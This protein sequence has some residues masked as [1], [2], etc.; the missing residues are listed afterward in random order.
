MKSELHK[1][2]FCGAILAVVALMS[3]CASGET[4]TYLDVDFESGYSEG[5]LD[6]QYGG[7]MSDVWKVKEPEE[8]DV[9]TAVALDNK[10]VASKT[11]RTAGALAKFTSPLAF[12]TGRGD[13]P[14]ECLYLSFDVFRPD[15]K[16]SALWTVM[17]TKSGANAGLG[18]F[19]PR[20]ADPVIEVIT[21][22]ACGLKI[23]PRT[24]TDFVIA[25][26]SWYRFE[27][28]ANNAT[29]KLDLFAQVLQE[30]GTASGRKIVIQNLDWS[31]HNNIVDAFE[32]LPQGISGH[33][34]SQIYTDNIVLETGVA[35][36]HL[37]QIGRKK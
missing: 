36:P 31:V 20:G 30:N 5:P 3:P 1:L 18:L 37:R 23:A 19:I 26:G 24:V 35:F 21:G 27:F 16:A 4:I 2:N 17:N 7:E 8:D 34:G 29:R 6:G 22:L 15:D 11:S 28:E 14:F 13:V 10:A 33:M 12:T 9:Q 32:I 25:N